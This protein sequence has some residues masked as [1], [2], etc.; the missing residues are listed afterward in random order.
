MTTSLE[1]LP[2]PSKQ[3]SWLARIPTS[4]LLR[5][6]ADTA[7]ILKTDV[8]INTMMSTHMCSVSDRYLHIVGN[9]HVYNAYIHTYIRTYI[10]THVVSMYVWHTYTYSCTNQIHIHIH[11][12]TCVYIYKHIFSCTCAHVCCACN[13]YLSLYLSSYLSIGRSVYLFT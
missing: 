2:L 9:I 1:P 5:E 13:K 4:P 8:Y 12:H 11:V 3:A 6:F 10:Q 7:R